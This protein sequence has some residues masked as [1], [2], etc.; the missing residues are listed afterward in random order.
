MTRLFASTVL[1]CAV[2]FGQAPVKVVIEGRVTS[3]TTGAPV[4][5]AVVALEEIPDFGKDGPIDP[6]EFD[7]QKLVARMSKLKRF[8][9]QTDAEGKFEIPLIDPGHYS[10][11]VTRVGYVR[12][13]EAVDLTKAEKADEKKPFAFKLTP[14]AVIS[15]KVLDEFSDPIPQVAVAV[16]RRNYDQGR[17]RYVQVGA[18]TTGADGAYSIGELEAG[19]YYVNASDGKAAMTG[20]VGAFFGAGGAPKGPRTDYVTT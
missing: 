6:A 13:V 16:F 11:A 2:A 15:G 14:Q 18:G 1:C 8:R 5:L 4:R 20:L 12:Y 17:W 7:A 19:R 3:S 9:G 10:L